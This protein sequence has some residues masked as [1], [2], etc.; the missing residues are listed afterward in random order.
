M[1]GIL[2]VLR[3][4][5][6]RECG[7]SIKKE[8]PEEGHALHTSDIVHIEIQNSEQGQLVDDS[9]GQCSV[10][11]DSNGDI[12]NVISSHEG[13]DPESKILASAFSLWYVNTS[14]FSLCLWYVI[15]YWRYVCKISRLRHV[16]Y[17]HADL[18]TILQ[19]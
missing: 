4:P 16:N 17:S 8:F 11:E 3:K 19:K 10:L 12:L 18:L 1:H 2:S 13:E 6:T 15:S 14:A 9:R 5:V 7:V